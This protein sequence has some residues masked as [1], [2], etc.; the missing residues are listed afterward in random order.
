VPMLDRL[1]AVRD[2][3]WVVLELSSFQIETVD[4]PRC[5]I[6]CVLNVTPDHLDR[7]GDFE[8]YAGIKR[9]IV[10]FASDAAVLGYDDPV[11]RAMADGAGCPVWYFGLRLDG[12]DGA[13]VRDAQIVSV[14]QSGT[15]P[16]MP[17]NA[18]PLFGAHNVLN[19]LAATAVTRAA[20]V[21]PDHIA[22]AVT[23]FRA[24][25]HRLQTVAEMDGVL[26]VNDS[27][28]TNAE[29]AVMA[30]QAFAG[31]PIVWIGGGRGAG[32]SSDALVDAVVDRARHAV[33]NGE[34][35]SQVDAALA[36]RGYEARTVVR[37]L[38]EA[39]AA[40]RDIARDGDVVLLAPGF[41]SFDQFRDFE[42]RGDSFIAF[43]TE[44]T[45][46]VDT[47]R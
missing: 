1:P 13:T 25:R 28:A 30:L 15:R 2:G 11:T 19:V 14:E 41:K 5:S 22:A 38:R 40:A 45:A 27:K 21:D 42:D 10:R 8:T 29:S 35:A 37:G 47:P 7:H 4:E 31:R 9:R 32:T 43:V 20:D 46:P 44:L 16:V 26:W 33:L 18:I 17:V 34:T 39:V 3:D 12:Q 6:A 23:S 36:A 24:V